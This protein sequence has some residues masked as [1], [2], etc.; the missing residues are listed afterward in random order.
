MRGITLQPSRWMLAWLRSL[1]K[2]LCG[3]PGFTVADQVV[4]DGWAAAAQPFSAPAQGL[5]HAGNRQQ[6]CRP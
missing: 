4:V 6:V 5:R 3:R 2:R 1:M